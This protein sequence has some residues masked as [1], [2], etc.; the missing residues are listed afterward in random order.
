MTP[1]Y[2]PIPKSRR[3]PNIAVTSRMKSAGAMVVEKLRDYDPHFVAEEVFNAMMEAAG[4]QPE[5]VAAI[6]VNL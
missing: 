5:S 3:G 1:D 4:E 2:L 6:K